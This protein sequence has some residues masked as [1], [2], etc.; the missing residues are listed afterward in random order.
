MLPHYNSYKLS[1]KEKLLFL[2]GGYVLIFMLTLLFY[3]SIILS[4]AS[5]VLVI[6]CIPFYEQYKGKR[7]REFLLVQFKDLLY[8]LASS[9][10]T[11]RQMSQALEEGLDNLRLLYEEETPMVQELVYMVKEIN[12]NREREEKILSDF[13]L[14]SGADDIRNF[15]DVYLTCRET[16]G[17]TVKVITNATDIIVEK[18]A[19][20]REIRTL[21][22][23]KQLEGKI[24]SLMPIG[25][26]LGLNIFYPDYLQVMYETLVGRIIMTLALAGIALAYQMTQKLSSIEV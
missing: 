10:A 11:G 18:M 22:A 12:E 17:D 23:Q 5:G 7:Q 16:G 2:P 13:A 21:T 24:I 4:F 26:V 3:R 19:I 20:Q 6:L 9:M 15:V 25:V 14:R 8:S 1:S